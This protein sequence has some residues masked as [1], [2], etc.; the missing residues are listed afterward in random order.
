MQVR[1]GRQVLPSTR[2]QRQRKYFHRNA[3]MIFGAANSNAITTATTT[4]FLT[5]S[6]RAPVVP[7]SSD[8]GRLPA[9]A[10]ESYTDFPDTS[11]A[12]SARERAPAIA[13]ESVT[14]TL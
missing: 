5:L 9:R 12:L 3:P 1:T 4:R 8:K 10:M 6:L 14:I 2:H 7:G 11:S 13:P